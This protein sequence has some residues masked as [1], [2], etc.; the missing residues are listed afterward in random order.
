MSRKK[1]AEKIDNISSALPKP[2]GCREEVKVLIVGGEEALDEY[3]H[4]SESLSPMG[5]D[6]ILLG[7]VVEGWP[8][9]AA[10][11]AM[12]SKIPVF[13]DYRE[14]LKQ[15]APD[16]L[17]ITSDDPK[18]R[19]RLLRTVPPQTR[20]I[21]SF[22]LRAFRALRMVSGQLGTAQSKLESVELIKEALM[23]NADISIMQVDEDFK[24]KEINN[25]YPPAHQNEKKGLPWSGLSLDNT[26][27]YRTVPPPRL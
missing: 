10:K 11:S 25:A 13:D 16:L 17:I 14:A 3:E 21:D 27:Q 12:D 19:K 23:A 20:I 5:L 2:A 1:R 26:P 15:Q 8:P 7:V 24:V 4:I 22:I 18:L 9:A 6:P